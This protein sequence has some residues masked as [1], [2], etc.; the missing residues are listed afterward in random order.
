MS[1]TNPTPP[2]R[3]DDTLGTGIESGFVLVI[4]AGGGFLL[5]RWLG[6]TPWLTIGLFALGAVG[7]FYRLRA[8]FDAQIEAHTAQRRGA[9]ERGAIERG[10]ERKAAP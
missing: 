4:F 9:V 2:A 5:D 7:V 10:T 6:T 3:P 8:A 1:P